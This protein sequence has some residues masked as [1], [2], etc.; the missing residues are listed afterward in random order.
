[1]VFYC[2]CTFYSAMALQV[3]TC[4][5][6][7]S[8]N[9]TVTLTRG[10]QANLNAHI[11]GVQYTR[12]AQYPSYHIDCPLCGNSYDYV[13][14]TNYGYLRSRMLLSYY[15]IESFKIITTDCG[16]VLPADDGSVLDWIFNHA[17][18]VTICQPKYLNIFFN[19]G[20]HRLCLYCYQ[21]RDFISGISVY[22]VY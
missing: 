15:S 4:P 22:K 16:T 9:P 14:I 20:D 11:A 5:I 6:C 3:I 7:N 12:G 13:H 21:Q 1:M 19:V 10:N 17:V 8:V 18:G 2:H